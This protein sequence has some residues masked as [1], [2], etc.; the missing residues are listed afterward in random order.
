[1][2]G[3]ISKAAPQAPVNTPT[4]TERPQVRPSDADD[5]EDLKKYIERAIMLIHSDETRGA[6]LSYLKGPDPVQK[7]ADATVMVMQRID[8]AARQSG[9]EVQDT[10]KMY[11]AHE[12]LKLVV[13]FGE[14]AGYF[15]MGPDLQEL[16]LSVAVQDYIKHEVQS[17]KINAQRLQAKMQID[18][19][20][21]PPKMKAEI[22][23]S[24]ARIQQTARKYA[25]SQKQV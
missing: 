7:V 13:E 6:I 21:M 20:K 17:G 25:A 15:K 14:A 1:M 22:Q 3:L 9:I 10:I 16:A 4:I 18:I 24:Q 19:R 23:A 11:G 2:N 5:R 8:D 12:I